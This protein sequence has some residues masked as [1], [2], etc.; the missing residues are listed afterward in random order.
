METKTEIMTAVENLDPGGVMAFEGLMTSVAVKPQAGQISTTILSFLTSTEQLALYSHIVKNQKQFSQLRDKYVGRVAQ[1][2]VSRSYDGEVLVTHLELADVEDA[3]AYLPNLTVIESLND[4]QILMAAG[5]IKSIELKKAKNGSVYSSITVSDGENTRS[6]TCFATKT[7]D[8]VTA[9]KTAYEGKVAVLDVL[10]SNKEKG[11]YRVNS[12]LCVV[13]PVDMAR[14]I[15]SSPVDTEK[16][17]T[18]IMSRLQ[19]FCEEDEY[20]IAKLACNIFENNK[21]Q[22]L[23]SSAAMKMHHETV[24]GLLFHIYRMMQLAD[25]FCEVYPLDRELLL[26]GVALHDIGK[27]RELNTDELGN[28]TYTVDGN[29]FGHVILG[30]DM[31]L[32]EYNNS[33]IE[34]QEENKERVRLLRHM[35]ISHHGSMENGSCKPPAI[36]EARALHDIDV[37]DSRF[38][39]YEKATKDLD[40]GSMSDRVWALNNAC[41]YR[42]IV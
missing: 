23:W 27:L 34:Y 39:S 9:Y 3:S 31:I 21:Q 29:L 38:Y 11:Y 14:Y 33:S 12:I 1:V 17:Y 13:Q 37:F 5:L 25:R 41:V 35:V 40:A 4:N 8:D 15:E 16:M 36:G 18:E 30:A 7:E 22:L 10:C 42:P 20:S 24:G 19:E 6:L 28:T 32:E 2:T 26:T